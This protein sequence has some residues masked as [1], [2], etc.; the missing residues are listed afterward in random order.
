MYGDTAV[1][2]A[3]ARSMR[4]RASD[5]RA[6]AGAIAAGAE[7]VPWTGL[8]ADAMRRAAHDHAG[9]VRACADAHEAA[10][11]ALE[12]HA[13]EVDLLKDLIGAIERRAG[14]LLESVAGGVAGSV[15]GLV[16]HVLPDGVPACVADWAHRFEPPPS[17]SRLWLDVQLPRSA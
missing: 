5:L 2:R 3:L 7:A 6:D 17:G 14:Q 15:A 10:A 13:V 12:R 4:E 1:V 8:A 9:M 11:E 16:D